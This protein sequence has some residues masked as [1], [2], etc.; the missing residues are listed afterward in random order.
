MKSELTERLKKHLETAILLELSTLP[1]YLCAYWSIHGTSVHAIHVKKF[2]LSVVQE[3]MLHMAMACNI[4]NAVSGRPA[5]N[6][7]GKLALFPCALP[8]HSKT[9]NAF[10]VRLNKCCP[11]AIATFLRIEL[12]E[13][14]FGN[15]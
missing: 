8:G 4:L 14:F 9:N 10:I 15:K 7:A 12:P 1:P 3:E 6:D 2:I 5:F 13:E 11:A